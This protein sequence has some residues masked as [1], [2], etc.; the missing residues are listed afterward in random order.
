M[1][2]GMNSHTPSLPNNVVPIKTKSPE[3]LLTRQ[4]ATEYID[5]DLGRPIK[6]STMQKLCALREGPPV[7]EYWGRRPLYSREDL[8][9]W[10]EAR[11][12]KAPGR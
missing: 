1:F 3:A 7:R 8:K 6:F 11:A 12:K 9:A 5:R 4:E 2:G 10:V